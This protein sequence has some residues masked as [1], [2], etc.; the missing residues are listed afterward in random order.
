MIRV[1]VPSRLHRRAEVL[2]ALSGIIREALRSGIPFP[3]PDPCIV[4][5]RGFD[6]AGTPFS[7]P[8]PNSV[9]SDAVQ[10]LIDKTLGKRNPHALVFFRPQQKAMII[11]VESAQQDKVVRGIMQELKQAAKSQF[12]K[13][14]PGIL[15]VQFIELGHAELLELAK[16][17]SPDPEKAS[18]LQIATSLFFQSP[19]RSHVLSIVYRSRGYLVKHAST[20]SGRVNKSWQEQGP[21]Y[22]FTNLNHPLAGDRRY[23]VFKLSG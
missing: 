6:L 8:D 11:V 10:E 4:E 22:F 23:S 17:D 3:G 14:R 13:Q 16:A 5:T 19:A 7:S 1:V 12:T 21:V 15:A 9:T 2:R 20:G 18:A